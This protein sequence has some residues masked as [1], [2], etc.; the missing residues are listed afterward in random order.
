MLDYSRNKYLGLYRSGEGVG[1]RLYY[2]GYEL[3]YYWE[4]ESS[5]SITTNGMGKRERVNCITAA[6]IIRYQSKL[7]RSLDLD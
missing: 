5:S 6:S 2:P 7:R 1:S 4:G 3:Y